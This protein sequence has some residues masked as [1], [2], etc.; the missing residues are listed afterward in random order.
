[1]RIQGTLNVEVYVQCDNFLTEKGKFQEAFSDPDWVFC[2]AFL[3]DIT[4]H[5]NTLNIRLQGRGKLVSDMFTDV[6]TFKNK[7]DIFMKQLSEEN[8]MH[9]STCNELLNERK[10]VLS[11]STKNVTRQYNF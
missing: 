5:L 8:F 3:S 6:K 11:A 10:N 9:F 7:L 2:L 4:D 1:M